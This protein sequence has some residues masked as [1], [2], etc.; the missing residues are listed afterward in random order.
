[1]NIL[2]IEY[3]IELLIPMSNFL[4]AGIF[5]REMACNFRKAEDKLS[6]R[7]ELKD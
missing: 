3:E 4:T 5:I 2:I 1:M 7:T 6:V